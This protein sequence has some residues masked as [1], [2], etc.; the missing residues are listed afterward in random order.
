LP[1]R[2]AI[3][4]KFKTGAAVNSSPVICGSKVIFGAD[5]GFLRIL[6]LAD[7]KEVWSANLAQPIASGPAVVENCVLVGCDDGYVY[8]FSA[9]N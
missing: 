9:I 3:R 7:G 1:A 4:W 8:V 5:D 2:L 6:N